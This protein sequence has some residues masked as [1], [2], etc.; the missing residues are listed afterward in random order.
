[1]IF[2]YYNDLE[3]LRNIFARNKAFTPTSDWRLDPACE[4]DV[5][6]KDESHTLVLGCPNGN[7]AYLQCT[8]DELGM[9]IRAEVINPPTGDPCRCEWCVP[10]RRTSKRVRAKPRRRYR[11]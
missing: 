5:Q 1:V 6:R 11:K 3:A 10:K 4:G 2:T 9:L 8:F 7:G